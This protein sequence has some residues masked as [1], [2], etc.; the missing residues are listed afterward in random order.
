[1]K[2]IAGL[3][4]PGAQYAN[5]RHNVGFMVC[6]ALGRRHGMLPGR[7][8]FKADVIEGAV[9]GA[10]QVLLIKPRT[11]M[12]L[13]GEAVVPALRF[14]KLEADALVVV[15]DEVDLPFGHVKL[16]LGGGLAGHNGLKSIV[17]H[18]GT[19]D[20]VRVR[21]GVGRPP[22]RQEMAD[23]VL[24]PFSKAEQVLLPFVIDRAMDAV[25]ALFKQGI[26]ASMNQMNGLP[27]IA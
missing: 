25:E 4:N 14:Y 6:D 1:M 8:R 2:V 11:Y 7:E 3:G 17:A 21:V 18:L 9:A 22:G 10:G 24:S 23:W 5:T 27:P 20:F 19:R 26:E 16:K 15:H 13:S 12:N